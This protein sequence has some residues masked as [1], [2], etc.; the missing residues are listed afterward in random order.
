MKKIMTICLVAV[1]S[2]MATGA[3]AAPKEE[4][5]IV[6]V[7]YITNIDCESCTKKI[8]GSIPYQRGVKKVEVD[9]PKAIVTVVYDATKNSDERIIGSLAKLDIAAKVMPAK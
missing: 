7:N 8:M 3:F 1:V 2:L 6:T 4:A 5:K 9:V